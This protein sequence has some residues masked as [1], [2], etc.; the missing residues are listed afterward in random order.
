MK[1]TTTWLAVN[2]ND[3]YVVFSEKPRKGKDCWFVPKSDSHTYD[4]GVM[5]PERVLTSNFAD[6]SFEDEPIELI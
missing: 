4:Y 1:H 5:I 2:K 6:L 3:M